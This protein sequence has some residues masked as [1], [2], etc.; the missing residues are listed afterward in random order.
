VPT[1]RRARLAAALLGAIGAAAAPGPPPATA[2]APTPAAASGFGV[3][4]VNV[5][6]AAGLVIPNAGGSLE[7]RTINETVGNGVCV[8]DVDGDGW[9][10]LYI[11]NG[12]APAGDTRQPPP[13]SALY[14][15]RA[16][17]AYEEIGAK[18]GV[19]LGGFWAQGCVFA[20]YDDD[21]RADLFVTGFG[22]YYLFRN[23]GGMR[24]EDVTQA[25]GL[26]GGR[27]WSTG[28]AFGDYDR[29]G[30]IDL[31]VSHY[32][33][34]DQSSPPLPKAGSDANCFYRGFPVMCGPRGLKPQMGRLFHNEGGRFRDV[35]VAAGMLQTGIYYGLGAVWSDLDND[36]D[37]DLYVATDS[38]PNLLYRNDGGGRFTE[39]GTPSGAA[40][41]EEGRSQASM[42]VAAGDLDR[43]GLDELFVTNFSHDYATLYHNEGGLYFSDVSLVA[44]IGAPTM[45]TLGWGDAFLDADNDGW[46]D[47][48][49]ANGHVYPGIDALNIG[50]TWKQPN[51]LFRNLGGMRFTDVTAVAGPA[52][53]EMH[54]ARGAAVA[55]LD[56]DGD[57][58]IVVNNIDEPPSLL[59]NDGGNRR[60]WI[61]LRLKGATRNRGAVGARVTLIAGGV[62]QVLEVQAGGS[63]NS[64]SDTRLLFGLAD[65]GGPVRAEVRW[66]SGKKSMFAE[67]AVDRY[68]D[69][70]E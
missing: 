59:R 28:A 22:R 24:F 65:A 38:T 25:A 52:F 40:F 17:L 42:G 5:A 58:D 70:A 48:F 7:K 8:A 49:L 62:R 6:A 13:R 34:Y 45:P 18:A 53:Q 32:V 31:Y 20:D 26:A 21:G 66:P 19:A 69:L 35:S 33:D 41:S 36:G 44:G 68:H 30:R 50:T 60:H 27:G 54:S 10:D 51:Q 4:F 56:N 3:Q 1:E 57:P 14:R 2:P 9:L 11:P 16:D 15:R 46:R 64:G 39:I 47:I 43:D 61:G 63:H 67:L 55:D 29:D 23:L 37:A 12:L